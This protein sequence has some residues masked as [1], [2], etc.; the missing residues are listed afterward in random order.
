MDSTRSEMMAGLIPLINKIQAAFAVGG[1]QRI[2]L[3]QIAVVGGQSSGKSSVLE[4]IVGKSFLPRGTGI[5]TRRPLVLQLHN[6]APGGAQYAEFV[7][8]P[9][10]RL[11]DFEA[12]RAEIEA[13]TARKCGR[14]LGVHAEPIVLAVHSP[15]V[16]DLTLIDLPG[17]TKVPVG[18]QPHDIEQ[19][20]RAMI[21]G[22]ISRDECIILAVTAANT[23][24]ANSDAIALARQVDPAGERTIGV[25]TKV[26]LMD[27]GTSARDALLGRAP[28][29]GG[30]A[31]S[32]TLPRLRL[33]YY[34]VVNRAQ[35]DI[36]E[37]K[38]IA[39]ALA[40]ERAFFDSRPEY[41]DC[42]ARV[43]C[44]VLARSC[45]ALLR[46]HIRRALPRIAR[47]LDA[48]VHRT[49]R[50]LLE[51]P[52]D[53]ADDAAKQRKLTELL[54]QVRVTYGGRLFRSLRPL[55]MCSRS[56]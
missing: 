31:T 43:T 49:R 11:S 12:I 30:L 47:E 7:H 32:D 22:F 18:D 54:M 46:A 25:L 39:D 45:A 48:L 1:A 16:L 20:I 9:G 17:T 26:D 34:G 5:V 21:L 52:E 29:P 50:E 24:L 41:A 51:L 13:E 33:G 44:P 37:R 28:D 14:N 27:R 10:E 42:G 35:Q 2:D 15:D 8:R 40:A 3:P 38:T 36:Q 55:R 53:M 4:A 23:D 56:L 6:V 19:Q